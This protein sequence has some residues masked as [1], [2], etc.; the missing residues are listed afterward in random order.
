MT[1]AFAHIEYNEEGK[2]K[3]MSFIITF[4]ELYAWLDNYISSIALECILGLNELYF[5]VMLCTQIAKYMELLIECYGNTWNIES[6]DQL[7]FVSSHFRPFPSTAVLRFTILSSNLSPR[8]I[9][10]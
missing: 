3:S 9:F 8:L 2:K 1:N 10:G 6:P 4:L 7:R 5:R